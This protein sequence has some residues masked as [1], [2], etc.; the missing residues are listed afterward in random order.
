MKTLIFGFLVFFFIGCS[1]D[2]KEIEI[3]S[4]EPPQGAIQVDYAELMRVK[5]MK[6]V[7]IVDVR[8]SAEYQ[9]GYIESA[10]S[11]PVDE[12]ANHL[13]KLR[14]YDAIVIY[15]RTNNRAT[16]AYNYLNNYFDEIYI[17]YEGYEKCCQ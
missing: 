17:F 14:K 4:Q 6:N 2:I 15:C 12:L 9:Q 8:T 7:A 13:D 11:I 16:Q 10:K 5:D 1:E 3:S